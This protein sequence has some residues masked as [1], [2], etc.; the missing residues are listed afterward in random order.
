MIDVWMWD[1][2]VPIADEY[3]ADVDNTRPRFLSMWN[4]M[5][6]HSNSDDQYLRL[7]TN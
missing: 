3:D 7:L 1:S 2:C 6:P 4:G 5:I